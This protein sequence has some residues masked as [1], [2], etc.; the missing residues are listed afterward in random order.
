MDISIPC[1]FLLKS[2]SFKPL[3]CPLI[4]FG[5]CFIHPHIIFPSCFQS[6]KRY[7]SR[8]PKRSIKCDIILS[9]AWLCTFSFDLEKPIIL[10]EST[11]LPA[12]S[13]FVPLAHT[14]LIAVVVKDWTSE[15]PT[16][17]GLLNTDGR[18]SE[19]MKN[20]KLLSVQADESGCRPGS[21]VK[22]P[23]YFWCCRCVQWV[24]GVSD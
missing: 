10:L 14:W 22:A 18:F 24:A 19:R 12:L 13:Q 6:V 2:S 16:A 5:L 11:W 17:V 1:F 21:A 3:S 7:K 9:Q 8:G 4:L 15:Q 23:S 20:A